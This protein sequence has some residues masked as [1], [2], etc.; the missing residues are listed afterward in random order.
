M[1]SSEEIKIKKYDIAGFETKNQNNFLIFQDK[2]NNIIYSFTEGK[3]NI[4]S[5]DMK[6]INNVENPDIKLTLNNIKQNIDGNFIILTTEK[7]FYYMPPDT[8]SIISEKEQIEDFL[9]SPDGKYIAIILEN[10]SV[11]KLYRYKKID[12]IKISKFD[13]DVPKRWKVQAINND[14]CLFLLSKTLNIICKIDNNYNSETIQN[15]DPHS[16]II[17]QQLSSNGKILIAQHAHGSFELIDTE[18]FKINKTVIPTNYCFMV[19]RDE[20]IY[21]V[22][23]NKGNIQ[24]YDLFGNIV[25]ALNFK[26][27]EPAIMILGIKKI[28]NYLIMYNGILE[29]YVYDLRINQRI[30]TFT[31]SCF[32]NSWNIRACVPFNNNDMIIYD[33]NYV[34]IFDPI[35]DKIE[36]KT[37]L[38]GSLIPKDNSPCSVLDF[39]SSIYF[40]RHLLPLIFEFLPEY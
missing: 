28:G 15:T 29:V 9:I 7:M 6:H 2:K 32:S 39:M 1:S 34:A 35:K 38:L 18:Q 12:E 21:T 22:D 26:V 20:F 40:D 37:F 16:Y 27:N 10:Y 23:S 8:F 5:T 14:G 17:N 11:V 30:K 24:I 25:Y 13:A 4:L 31:F 36:Q 33:N 3:I 19:N